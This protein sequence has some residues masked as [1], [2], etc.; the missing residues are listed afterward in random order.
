MNV[1]LQSLFHMM[2]ESYFYSSSFDTPVC[3]SNQKPVSLFKIF[4]K[5]L[6]GKFMFMENLLH[7][8]MKSL[9]DR[10]GNHRAE[11]NKEEHYLL[12]RLSPAQTSLGI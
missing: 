4:S 8:R 6:K 3:L 5:F 10:I 11:V 1:N 9:Q 2:K 7:N 12:T